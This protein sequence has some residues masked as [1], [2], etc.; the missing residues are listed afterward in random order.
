MESENKIY[1]AK[2]SEN[3]EDAIY[4]RIE[5]YQRHGWNDWFATCLLQ[6]TFEKEFSVDISTEYL[7]PFMSAYSKA[8]QRLIDEGRLSA[9][10]AIKSSFGGQVFGR[11]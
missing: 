9:S 11:M 2:D 10:G 3:W 8:L 4:E 1:L 6:M 7:T 5:S